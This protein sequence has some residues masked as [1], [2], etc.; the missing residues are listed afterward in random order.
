MNVQSLKATTVC[1]SICV[2]LL[3]K[4]AI[5]NVLYGTSE[6]LSSRYSSYETKQYVSHEPKTLR[7]EN[8]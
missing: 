3:Q 4:L 7:L 2:I 5:R 8:I 6:A 1:I